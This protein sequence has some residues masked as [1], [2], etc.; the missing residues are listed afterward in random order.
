MKEPGSVPQPSPLTRHLK[1]PS[2][3]PIGNQHVP[4]AMRPEM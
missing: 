4:P 3:A 1:L 2:P